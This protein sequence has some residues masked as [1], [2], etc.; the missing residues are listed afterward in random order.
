MQDASARHQR[1]VVPKVGFER[2]ARFHDRYDIVTLIGHGGMG[3]VYKATD[4]HTRA[5]RALKI[6]LPELVSDSVGRERFLLEATIPAKVKH[7]RLVAVTDT[8]VDDETGLPFLAMAF[9]DGEDLRKILS[10]HGR[11]LPADAIGLLNR[12]PVRSL[13]S[14]HRISSIVISNQRT[15]SSRGTR[16]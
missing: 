10:R 1:R 8:G 9:L 7:P 13:Q 11:L 12:W 6:M 2:G 15:Y 3:A 4:R 14:T 16:A 5:A